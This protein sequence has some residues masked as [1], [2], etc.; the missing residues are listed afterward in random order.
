M[1][2]EEY[3]KILMSKSEKEY[4]TSYKTDVLE[5]YKIYLEMTDRISSR[6]QTANSFFLTINTAIVGVVSYVHL[7]SKS[8]SFYW[9]VGI[10]GVLLCFTW[11]RL[12]R[13][14]KDMNSGKFKI[15]HEIEKLLPLAI[16]DAEW[17]ALGRGKDAK[18]YL[19]FT[20]VELRVPIIFLC[21]HLFVIFYSI[22]W[23]NVLKTISSICE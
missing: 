17:E 19:Q 13:S 7:G 3:K 15:I 1:N 18:I 20:K 10:A 11:Y 5:L 12:I 21:I 22:P 9:F 23:C 8:N 2:N 16:Y 4:G 6:R 14:Y